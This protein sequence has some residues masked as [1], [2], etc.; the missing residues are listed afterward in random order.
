MCMYWGP[1]QAKLLCIFGTMQMF[2]ASVRNMWSMW[3]QPLEGRQNRAPAASG[4]TRKHMTDF[5]CCFGSSG[6]SICFCARE[7][8][9]Q[10]GEGL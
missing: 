2:C 3:T 10:E 1:K 4:T 9:A 6:S 7:G 8:A 5:S